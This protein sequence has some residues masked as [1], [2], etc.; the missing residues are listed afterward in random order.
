MTPSVNR[1]GACVAGCGLCCTGPTLPVP[2][3][4]LTPD[5]EYWLAGY[6]IKVWKRGAAF[7]NVRVSDRDCNYLQEDKSCGRQ[8]IKPEVCKGWPYRPSDLETVERCG[9]SFE[10][11]IIAP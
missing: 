3:A 1:L 7:T 11:A 8:A 2:T 10:E 6:G 4:W 5:V 9:Y